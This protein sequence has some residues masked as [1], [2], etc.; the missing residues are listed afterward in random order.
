MVGRCI[1][2]TKNNPCPEDGR[3]LLYF[4]AFQS[5]PVRKLRFYQTLD[6]PGRRPGA[7]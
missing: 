3:G 6:S 1:R 7:C 5:V 2:I 4:I